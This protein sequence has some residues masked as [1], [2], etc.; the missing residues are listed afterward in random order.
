MIRAVEPTVAEPSREGRFHFGNGRAVD[1]RRIRG[2]IGRFDVLSVCCG[3]PGLVILSV[4]KDLDTA[5]F[6]ATLR[7][8][9][10]IDCVAVVVRH[11][12][13]VFGRLQASFDLQCGHAGRN[14]FRQAI[15]RG[16]IVGTEGIGDGFPIPPSR[17]L[18]ARGETLADDFVRQ[19]ARLC[20]LAAVGA[21]PAHGKAGKALARVA[22]AERAVDEHLDLDIRLLSDRCD[23]GN[24]R[25]TRQD[26]SAHA[27]GFDLGDALRAAERH[28]GR[29]VQGQFGTQAVEQPEQ[30][31]VLDEYGV[32]ARRRQQSCDP[33]GL[34]QFVAE[35]ER[36]ERHV[37]P[38]AARTEERHQFGQVGLAEIGSPSA[39]VESALQA[40]VN[41]VG[42]ILDGGPRAVP[43]ACRRHEFGDGGRIGHGADRKMMDAEGWTGGVSFRTHHYITVGRFGQ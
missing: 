25:F 4:A 35:D 30:S 23:L 36:V 34:G 2:R 40:E 5:G 32:N 22:D 43:V 21:A 41:G 13:D 38:N 29:R 31:D 1:V 37:S 19:P 42:P 17:R 6:F 18:V 27:Q 39:S 15:V 26:D 10:R 3:K 20:A 9:G 16:E 8:T 14:E 24:G 11:A 28:L 12:G 7:M 33:F